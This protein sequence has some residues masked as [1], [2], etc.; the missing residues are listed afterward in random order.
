MMNFNTYRYFNEVAETRSIRRAADR[1]H[2]APSAISRQLAI[3]EHSLGT[4]LLERTNTGIQLTPAG[5][6]L[7][8]YTRHMFRDLE[9]VQDSIKNLKG[10]RQGEVKIWVIEGLIL[11]FLPRVIAEFNDSFPAIKFSVFSES[12]DRIIEAIIKDEADI[13]VVYNV[14]NRPGIEI[15]AHYSEP[16]MC[17]ASK[18]HPFAQRDSVT[19]A[20]VCSQQ[21]SIPFAS[22]GL[23]QL[24][25]K[26]VSRQGLTPDVLVSSNN[27]E[28]TKTMAMTGKTLAIGPALAARKEIRDGSLKAIPIHD[29]DFADATSAV[30]VHRDRRLSYAA[31]EFLK[32]INKAFGI[33]G[34]GRFP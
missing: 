11:D 30:C 23:R 17:L 33:A 10:L 15:V 29:A 21:I 4:L 32:K 7:E 1:L 34:Q 22:F 16:V 12:T 28:L 2:I 25:D 13:G 5:L 19:L 8:R 26:A 18:D 14:K 27:L 9:R 6:M 20:E 24:F 31:N 3:L